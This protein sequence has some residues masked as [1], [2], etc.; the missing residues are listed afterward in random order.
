MLLIDRILQK[1]A[2][3][4]A[5]VSSTP[6]LD[7][8]ILMAH[9]LDRE[10]SEMLLRRASLSPPENFIALMERRMQ[11]EPIAYIIGEQYFWDVTLKVTPDVLIPRSDSETMIE[12]IAEV[13][14]NNPPNHILDLGTGSGALLLAALSVFENAQGIGADKSKAALKLARYNSEHNGY[15]TR[16][17]FIENDWTQPNWTRAFKQ[18]FDMI[19]CNPPYICPDEGLMRDVVDYEPLSALFASHEGLGDYQ[20]LIP[21][22]SSLLAENG[23]IFLEIGARQAE[24]VTNIAIEQAYIVHKKQDLAGNDRILML[25]HQQA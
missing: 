1:A 6:R 3:D 13:G 12:W 9:A 21:N 25:Q 22:L 7:A 18:R 23:K 8:E 17:V 20:V 16:S 24:E 15:G 2:L 11:Y 19:L 10:R 5:V 14:A 4:L